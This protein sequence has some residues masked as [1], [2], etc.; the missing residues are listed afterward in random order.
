MPLFGK[1]VFNKISGGLAETF[2]YLIS[3]VETIET[4]GTIDL[5]KAF[6]IHFS[7][8]YIDVYEIIELPT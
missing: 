6:K 8:Y 4:T 3:N 1:K 5:K 7:Y 2:M